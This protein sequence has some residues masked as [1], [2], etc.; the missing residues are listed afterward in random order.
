MWVV[1]VKWTRWLYHFKGY[2]FEPAMAGPHMVWQ[3]S[4]CP[5][6]L[7]SVSKLPHRLL[8]HLQ[9]CSSKICPPFSQLATLQKGLP[10]LP[11]TYIIPVW[12]TQYHICKTDLETVPSHKKNKKTGAKGRIL[13]LTFMEPM[14][15]KVLPSAQTHK[16][17]GDEKPT[18]LKAHQMM[19]ITTLQEKGS[20]NLCTPP[21]CL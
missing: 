4:H 5:P 10:P 1:A 6:S 12:V 21:F 3:T 14:R 17:T 15:H 2:K 20:I 13:T 16:H 11:H 18:S 9:Q 19:R 7:P 8:P